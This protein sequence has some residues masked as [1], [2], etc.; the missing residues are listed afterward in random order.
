MNTEDSSRYWLDHVVERVIKANPKGEIVVSSGISPSGP[1]HVGHAREILT[2]DAIKRGLEERGRKVR[3]LHFVDNFDVLRKRYPYLDESYESEVG[4]PL[5][6]VPA[7]NNKS[8]NYGEQ[9]FAD[10]QAAAAL[11]GVEM[12]VLKADQLYREGQFSDMIM[13]CL[14][15]RDQIAKILFEVSGRTVDTDWQPIQILDESSQK[16]NTAK[17]LSYDKQTATVR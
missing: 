6:F 15:K 11:L 12:E 9:F 8:E 1:Y 5:Y 17:F 4:K 2:A 13:L 14:E 16:L 10:Y 7:P 3:H